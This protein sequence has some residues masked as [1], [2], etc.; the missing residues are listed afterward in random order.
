MLDL[1]FL[2][3]E[4]EELDDYEV[5]EE[6]SFIIN[7]NKL[8]D[9]DYV[10]DITNDLRSSGG[11]VKLTVGDLLILMGFCAVPLTPSIPIIALCVLINMGLYA[12][13]AGGF[14]EDSQKERSKGKLLNALDKMI[15]KTEKERDSKS[16][17]SDK[18]R[19]DREI[20]KLKHNREL[21]AKA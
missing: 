12:L 18:E 13:V 9:E 20:K 1:D 7:K 15:A 6:A 2:L 19:L 14:D 17:R 16:D 5:V 21:I 3:E 8:S 4:Y 11:K 10:K